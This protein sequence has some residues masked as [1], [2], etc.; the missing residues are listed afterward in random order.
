MAGGHFSLKIKPGVVT[1]YGSQVLARQYNHIIMT[2]AIN[3][4]LGVIIKK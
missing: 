1:I 3:D 2:G 4:K